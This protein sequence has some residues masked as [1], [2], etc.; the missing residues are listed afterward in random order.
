MNVYGFETTVIELTNTDYLV[1][2]KTTKTI[3]WF[4]LNK[5][6]ETLLTRERLDSRVLAM[7][8][9]AQDRVDGEQARRLLT[10][11]LGWAMGA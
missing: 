3:S 5:H 1:Y 6:G 7:A 10:R 4:L 9:G 8:V 11:F 2:H